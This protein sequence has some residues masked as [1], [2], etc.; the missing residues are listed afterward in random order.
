MAIGGNDDLVQTHKVIYI[1][2]TIEFYA[3]PS[4]KAEKDL[5]ITKFEDIDGLRSIP[6]VRSILKV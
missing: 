3:G 4:M 1:T 2:V 5:E 6:N